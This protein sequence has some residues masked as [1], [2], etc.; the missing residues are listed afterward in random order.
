MIDKID[1]SSLDW[2]SLLPR[3]GVDQALIANPKKQGP[4]PI[5]GDG[6]TRFRF[7]NK[8]GRGTWICNHCG[9]GDGVQ[10]VALI[11]GTDNKGA[12]RLIREAIGG[13]SNQKEYRRKTAIVS[14]VKTPQEI[15]KARQSLKRAWGKAMAIEDTP[16]LAYLKS[17]VHALNPEW[18]A[19]SFRYH[20]SMFHFDEGTAN[21]SNLPCMLSRVVDASSPSQV[22]TIHRTYITEKGQK[23]NVT[24]DQVKKLMPATVEKVRGES[25]KLNTSNSNIVIVTEGIEN[26][27]AWVMACKNRYSVYAAI[28]CNNMANFKWP[29]GTTLLL[30]AG[31]HDRVNP[32]TGLRPGLHNALLLKERATQSGIKAVVK[33]PAVQDIDW[34]DLWNVGER[35]AFRL[36]SI[37]KPQTTPEVA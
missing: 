14:S 2:Y 36:Q 10:L 21:K 20:P 35:D 15:E 22:V 31:D 18:L 7:D 24:P 3:L 37:R 29:Q 30:I 26:G 12:V 19:P 5:E 13:E 27:L 6:K 17:R 32:K 25:I 34:D 28:N 8:D 9:A 1:F 23:A 4:C 16:A 33:I 11:N